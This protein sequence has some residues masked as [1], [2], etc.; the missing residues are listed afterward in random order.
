VK[1]IVVAGVGAL[2]SH[3]VQ[4]LR[5]VDATIRIIDFD[6]VE[7]RNVAS[8]F[9]GKPG[10][11]RSK[12]QALKQAMMFLFGRDLETIPHR[13]GPDN[14]KELLGGADLVIDCLDNGASRR[15]LQHFVRGAGV[16]CLHGALAGDGGFGRV[17]W[18]EAFVVDDES[19]A[20]A[21]TCDDG[22]HLPFI[23][24]TSAYLARVAQEFL[25]RGTKIGF[26]IH[27]GGATRT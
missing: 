17:V 26:E 11:G 8:Q 20:G 23:A 12:V 3:V 10:V 5:N 25:A 18:D 14:A 15:V 4:L 7:Q 2:G 13:L 19:A 16:A 1:S 27:A 24:V 22:A 6:K 21:A 9:H